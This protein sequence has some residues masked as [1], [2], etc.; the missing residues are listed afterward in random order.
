MN[1]H[2]T[3][4]YQ[5]N[6]N[7]CDQ[8]PQKA[9]LFS[10]DFL[11][12][13]T[14]IFSCCVSAFS[15]LFPCCFQGAKVETGAFV[16]K[17]I[18]QEQ[19]KR[20]PS[21]KKQVMEEKSL[22]LLKAPLCRETS[23]NKTAALFTG[24]NAV[25]ETA[26]V[27]YVRRYAHPIDFSERPPSKKPSQEEG[28]S[29]FNLADLLEKY[30]KEI[31]FSKSLLSEKS[32]Q[33]EGGSDFS[34]ADLLEK[35]AEEVV[36]ENNA[37]GSKTGPIL[38]RKMS[39]RHQL[40]VFSSEASKGSAPPL[41]SK[42]GS[43]RKSYGI[44]SNIPYKEEM[45]ALTRGCFG[46]LGAPKVVFGSI[47]SNL[48]GAWY[49]MSAHSGQSLPKLSAKVAEGFSSAT[50]NASLAATTSPKPFSYSESILPNSATLTTLIA[51][52]MLTFLGYKVFSF[53]NQS[54]TSKT[55]KRAI[56][57]CER[58]ALCMKMAL[59]PTFLTMMIYYFSRQEGIYLSGTYLKHA[60]VITIQQSSRLLVSLMSFYCRLLYKEPVAA[61][62]FP[63]FS[64]G[65]LTHTYYGALEI[66][67]NQ[68]KKKTLSKKEIVKPLERPA[69]VEEQRLYPT[70][71]YALPLSISRNIL[72]IFR[73]ILLAQGTQERFSTP[74][75]RLAGIDTE[76]NSEVRAQ[77][78]RKLFGNGFLQAV[79]YP[80][81][82][83]TLPS[84]SFL[85]KKDDKK[86]SS[87][88]TL[89][90]TMTSILTP[91]EKLTWKNYFSLPSRKKWIGKNNN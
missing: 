53:Y 42:K 82:Q 71:S 65:I 64:V 87:A 17:A 22:D 66:Q 73:N 30:G 8:R 5:K 12:T 39:Q 18:S 72:R 16:K 47:L 76:K 20:H 86:N 88:T 26:L 11:T 33:E 29:D 13:I 19:T 63:G 70:N 78:L 36:T 79:K 62:F 80:L 4:V 38:D 84:F 31:D 58:T 75:N 34:L 32:S 59:L 44:F 54:I 45:E 46:Y 21:V 51:C 23:G 91:S 10:F 56:R 67:K 48:I 25:T 68:D 74:Y 85:E 55:G 6:L 24:N 41:L 69:K 37:A 77:F 35:H 14:Q 28:F 1:I 50:R 61:V 89:P 83:K 81:F 7:H 27:P 90:L 43:T 15:W 57:S 40:P 3:T 9:S 2:P 60:G 49:V 52:G